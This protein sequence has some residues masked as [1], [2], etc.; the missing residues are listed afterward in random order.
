[1]AFGLSQGLRKTQWQKFFRWGALA[2]TILFVLILLAF[3]A[4]QLVVTSRFAQYVQAWKVLLGINV[5]V[6]AIMLS[7]LSSQSRKQTHKIIFIGLAPVL[8]FLSAHLLIPDA[9]LAKRAPGPF[10]ARYQ[11]YL[12]KEKIIIAEH[13]LA[14]AVCWYLKRDDVYILGRGGE[15]KYG[16][17]Y[18]NAAG[19]Q[20]ELE[21]AADFIEHHPG[22]VILIARM[23]ELNKWRKYLPQPVFTKNN[24]T[25]GI[26]L[27]KF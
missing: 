25:K 14:G 2:N 19:R 3:G 7:F 20:I 17:T 8:I 16:L 5:L 9:T 23:K 21:A 13:R 11:P 22:K 26:G 27:W 10:L 12:T 4:T 18:K 24:A 15:F 6:V 1:M